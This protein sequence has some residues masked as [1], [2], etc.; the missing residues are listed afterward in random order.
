MEPTHDNNFTSWGNISRVQRD[1]ASVDQFPT[2][3]SSFLPFGN[4]R[5]YGDTCLNDSGVLLPMQND[6][7]IH[8]FDAKTGL[9]FA[10]AG[11]LLRDVLKFTRPFGYFLEVTPGTSFVTLGGAIANDVHGKNHHARGT[12]GRSVLSF[13]LL[14]SDRSALM[15]CSPEEN[16]EIFAATI[17]GMGLTGV[18]TRV[19]L[20]LMEVSSFDVN[21][22][23]LRF[24]NLDEY[25][26][27]VEVIDDAHE[28]SVA[29]IDQLARGTSFGRGVLMAG[30]HAS[31]E[32]GHA[33]AGERQ[34]DESKDAKLSVP[35]TSPINLINRW[36]LAAFN[37]AYYHSFSKGLSESMEPW[38]SYF[39]P[40]D[41][42]K[43]WNRLYG[44]KGL[45]QHQS[46]YPKAAARETTIELL[47]CAKRFN[48]GS[49]LTV[50]KSFGAQTTPA[51]FSFPR[52]GFTLTLDFAN[53]GVKTLQLLDALDEIVLKAGGAV[54]PYKD[55]RMSAETF[56]QSFPNWRE[57]EA[58]RDQKICSDFWR[59]TALTLK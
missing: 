41:A 38:Q 29:W 9:L 56:A 13:D 26:E 54:N 17:G 2:S 59:R 8:Q 10:D 4:G 25:F 48:H 36:S 50:L 23:T 14:R 55:H 49:F 45:Y 7:H 35:F 30:N 1:L 42:I 39:Y 3:Q 21:Q 15:H 19:C 51:L 57:L 27:N 44:P 11:V 40:L 12:F 28:Y 20:R 58:H 16:S 53:Q 32:E 47:E 22:K 37:F 6:A 18:I 33:M 43:G 34:A 24:N 31:V 46:V 5:S 52:E